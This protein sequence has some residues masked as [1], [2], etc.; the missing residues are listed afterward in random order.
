VSA[1]GVRPVPGR[2]RISSGGVILREVTLRNGLATP[3]IG[4]LKPGLRTFKFRYLGDPKVRQVIAW[5]TV[6]IR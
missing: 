5:K 2:V 6:R 3:T 4:Q 1:A